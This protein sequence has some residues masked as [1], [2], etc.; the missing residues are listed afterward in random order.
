MTV[1]GHLGEDLADGALAIDEKGGA[2]NA[3]EIAPVAILEDVDAV[4]LRDFSLLV[5]Q[6]RKRQGV[7][8]AELPMLLRAVEADADDF[9]VFLREFGPQVAKG[10]RFAGAASRI[11]L[12]VKVQ[13]HP[14]STQVR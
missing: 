1:D 5:S 6:Q 11:V 8:F 12:R 10:A 7:F 9:G 2:V 13:N 14:L 3:P 4:L